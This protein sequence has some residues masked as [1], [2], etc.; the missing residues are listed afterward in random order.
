MKKLLFYL[1]LLS[2][3]F[4]VLV[5]YAAAPND[6]IT[7]NLPSLTLDFNKGEIHRV[8]PVAIGKSLSNTPEGIYK[9]KAKVKDPTWY[10]PDGSKP[11]PP[12]KDN[13]LGHRWINFHPGYG[14]HGNNNSK[15]ISTL[16]SLGCVRMYNSDVEE[17]Y[18]M[19]DVG[20]P[21]TII[22]QTM[23]EIDTADKKILEV[24]PDLYGRGVNSEEKIRSKLSEMGISVYEEK[25]KYILANYEKRTSFFSDGW[26]L[27]KWD[28]YLSSDLL[29]EN[30]TLYISADA[31]K[32]VFG[33]DYVLNLDTGIMT[34]N[35]EAVNFTDKRGVYI[36]FIQLLEILKLDY[37]MDMKA[38]RVDITSDMVFVNGK[39]VGKPGFVNY[40][41][42]DIK[43][44]LKSIGRQLG[45]KVEWDAVTNTV[46]VDSETVPAVII[47]GVSYL[48][49]KELSEIFNFDY[50]ISSKY[51]II[52]IKR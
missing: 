8:Y 38:E 43:L 42:R 30:G 26:I 29:M 24:Y 5:T 11:V 23:A 36:D 47:N 48:G 7:I 16:A 52:Q 15:S 20:M 9:V 39:Y 28:R 50:E 46:R 27:T 18:E 12:G 37:E 25:F 31:V 19:V 40:D 21:V 22:Y 44:P 4:S 35:D 6:G 1:I 17:L 41:N 13:P 51:G 45:Y 49:I 14:I 10:P 2:I 32:S 33:I 34:V 3:C